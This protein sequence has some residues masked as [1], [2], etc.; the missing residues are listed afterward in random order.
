[1]R[2]A[3]AT[4]AIAASLTGCAAVAEP[5]A[6]A[7]KPAEAAANVAAEAAP[8]AGPLAGF[9]WFAELAG[10]CW[11]G[12]YPDGKAIDTQCYLAQYGRL[13]RG[14][15]RIVQ[16]D[17]PQ[18]AFEGDAVFAVDPAGGNRIVFTQWGT[19]GLYVRGEITFEGETLVFRNRQPD[20]T[21]APV[22]SIWRRTG[23]D[24]F[25]VSRERSTDKGWLP[26]LDVEY[27][28]AR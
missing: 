23:P 1:M 3:L 8:A 26:L 28:R 11:K 6:P 13:M 20:G 5:Q 24:G 10:S 22:R 17:S 25:H 19:G 4:V 14:A 21:E 2:H 15:S 9:G 16:P 27:R 12:E 18:P 7:P